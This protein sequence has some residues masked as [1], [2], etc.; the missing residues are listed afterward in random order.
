[1]QQNKK[2]KITH[3]D[4]SP[5]INE[6]DS[7]RNILE[8]A[9]CTPA[10]VLR[11]RLTCKTWHQWLSD[12]NISSWAHGVW[13][14]I[15][16]SAGSVVVNWDMAKQVD[17]KL[18]AMLDKAVQSRELEQLLTQLD[19]GKGRYKAFLQ[20]DTDVDNAR[21]LVEAVIFD[22]PWLEIPI[23][24]GSARI[25]MKQSNVTSKRLL[26]PLKTDNMESLIGQYRLLR[27]VMRMCH[28]M[29]KNEVSYDSSYPLLSPFILP[30]NGEPP[31][32]QIELK[33]FA[34]ALGFN[35]DLVERTSG[36]VVR[37]DGWEHLTTEEELFNQLD[38]HPEADHTVTDEVLEEL[39]K[40]LPMVNLSQ[41]MVFYQVQLLCGVLPLMPTILCHITQDGRYIAGSIGFSDFDIRG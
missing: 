17:G 40:H 5:L 8:F 37:Y 32:P 16:Q 22:D 35:K 28:W 3:P 20:R 33:K 38:P 29:A 26:E 14:R 34:P 41:E 19:S 11:V 18:G 7:L 27:A 4:L 13:F 21:S 39:K 31:G 25:A 1:M 15:V 2:L 30:W 23:N 36:H 10:E 12:T 6:N 9:L 24:D